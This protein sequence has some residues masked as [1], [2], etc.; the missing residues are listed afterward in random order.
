MGLAATLQ[1]SVDLHLDNE[2]PKKNDFKAQKQ[3]K[4]YDTQT[5]MNVIK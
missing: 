2:S 4:L 3:A 1:A 5:T